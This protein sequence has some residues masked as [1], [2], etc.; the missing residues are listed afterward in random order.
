M[1]KTGKVARGSGQVVIQL[2]QRLFYGI[3]AVIG[4][5]A[6]FF[7]GLMLGRLTTASP[8]QPQ[9]AAF[10]QQQVP[11]A[12]QQGQPLQVQQV[13][14]GQQV[15]PFTQGRDP[16]LL[17]P[18]GDDVPIGD[19]PRLTLPDLV[20]TDYNWDFGDIGPEEVAEKVFTVKNTGTQD[21]VID[22]VTSSCG[23]T[24][25]LL[26]EKTIPPGDEAQLRVSY[27]PRVNKDRGK[28]I[29]RYVDIL[30]NDPAAPQVR[31]TITAYVR[32]Q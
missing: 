31:F 17:K 5:V 22:R 1:S 18:A 7:V 12:Q 2:D 32:E 6:I 21:L 27:D 25:A 11:L 28:A 26:S 29:T 3:I 19:N 10:P 4:I 13:Q 9:T 23:C 8:Q 15:P 30:S 24:A 16:N 20:D 14:P